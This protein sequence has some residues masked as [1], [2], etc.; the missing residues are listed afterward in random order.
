VISPGDIGHAD[1]SLPLKPTQG[2]NGAPRVWEPP[3]SDIGTLRS[4]TGKMEIRKLSEGDAAA[5][6]RLR[7]EA[8]ESEPLAF[9]RAVEEHRATTLKETAE[10]IREKEDGSFT[11]GGFDGE[12]LVAT[13]TFKRQTGIKEGHKG[14]LLGVYVC[15][16]RRGRG[17]GAK[18]METLLGVAKRD[19]SLEQILLGVGSHNAAA[20]Q[21]YRKF[22]FEP[23]GT[24]PRAL[25]VGSEYVDEHLMILRLR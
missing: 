13:A 5:W 1:L 25:K 17:F 6:W 22:G 14:H 19:P 9:G 24:E 2:L 4:Q 15:A 23:Y 10:R 21:I 11:L 18:L 20:I 3:K 16:S 12:T 8:L 7:L